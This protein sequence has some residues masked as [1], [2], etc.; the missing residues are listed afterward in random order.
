MSHDPVILPLQGGRYGSNAGQALTRREGVLKVTGRATYAADNHPEGMLYAVTAVSRIARGRVTALD[1]AAAKAHPGVIEVLTSANR[2]P[3]SHDP[4][5]KVPPFGFRVEVL[6]DDSVRYA[7]QP[8]ALVVAETLEAATEGAALLNPQYKAEPA[9]TNLAN[10]ERYAP[11]MIGMGAPTRTAFGDVEAG[12]A[13]AAHVTEAE[14]VTPQQYHNAMEPHAVVAEWNGDRLTLDMP[15][16]A[17]VMSCAAYGM[18]LAF[19]RK[20]L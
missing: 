4:N 11:P 2:P 9:R 3:L 12:L 19:R 14:F 20:T 15:N 1:V 6:Q 17:L 8:I 10:G 7:N 5:E 18:W 16:Q 13:A